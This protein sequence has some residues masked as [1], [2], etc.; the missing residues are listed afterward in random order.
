[1][2][3][4]LIRLL[5]QRLN[6]S[7]ERAENTLHIVGIAGTVVLFV[8]VSTTVLS[9]DAIFTAGRVGALNI[10]DVAERNILSPVSREF[11][12]EILTQRSREEAANSVAD[13]Y[14]PPDINVIR[15]QTQLARQIL[16]FINNVRR[17]PFGTV[18]QKIND[19]NQISALTLDE[20]I[21]REILAMSPETW[22]AVDDQIGNVLERVMREPIR[23]STLA[24]VIDQLPTQVAVRFSPE[25]SAAI[26]A[27][28]ED[29]VRPNTFP[30]AEATAAAEQAAAEAVQPVVR[31]FA[32]NE[33]VVREGKRIDS[34]DYEALQQLG[35]LKSE[36]LR[37]QEIARAFLA[38]VLVV[39]VT[40]LYISRFDFSLFANTRSL[41]LLT[42][43]FL[44][45]L[46]GA[47]VVGLN[48]GQ[49]YLY[50]TAALA[51]LFVSLTSPQ[52][53]IIAVLSLAFLSSLAINSLLEVAVYVAVGGLI[54]MLVLRRTERLNAYFLAGLVIGLSNT[55]VVTLFDLG[56]VDTIGE[57]VELSVL[58][59]YSLINGLLAAAVAVAGM[60]IIT[61]LFNFPTS[62]KLA[63]LSQPNQPL[64]QR[65]LREAPGTYQHSLQVANLSEQAALAVG[66]QADL[67]R[68]AALYH[69]IGKM[70]NPVFFT[71]NTQFGGGNPHDVLNDPY[72]SADII[73]SHV[74]DGEEMAREYRLPVRFRDFIMEHHGTTRVFVFYKQAVNQAEGDESA[75]DISEFTYPGPRPQS[76]ETGIM[77]LADS[78]E[79]AVRSIGPSSKQEIADIVRKIFD[80]K[81]REGQLDDSGL[82]LRDIKT[83]QSVFVDML[84]AV[85]HPRINYRE[86]S[87]RRPNGPAKTT[88]T[89]TTAAKPEAP[90]RAA[91]QA[92]TV[93]PEPTPAFDD[94]EDDDDT[95]MADVPTLP[96]THDQTNNNQADESVAEEDRERS[97]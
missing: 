19:I 65:L 34:V 71:E 37:L 24:T 74:T 13:V 41:L 93:T 88:K 9:F 16:D 33:I 36:D 57:G 67:V 43:I 23:E 8:L 77:M 50:P 18:E 31:T 46:V 82:T 53:T 39:V 95:P 78:C 30:N 86:A 85:F 92:R 90:A 22:Q 7:R 79:A 60:Y 54:G 6:F 72:R 38:S 40:G 1:M 62:L 12:S 3:E 70:L 91:T 61:L 44:I 55:V 35:L 45:V 52:I 63:E 97:E 27:I 64:L 51:L 87:T 17:D 84:Q 89:E 20:T 10:G 94:L 42:V 59:L 75:V 25:E 29:L 81:M 15:Q 28:V 83:I 80:D 48:E 2:N 14:D 73:I 21:I 26:V 4:W 56:A 69:D 96:R 5:Q 32:T 68:V 49:L 11:A 47:R 76:R 58:V 66:A